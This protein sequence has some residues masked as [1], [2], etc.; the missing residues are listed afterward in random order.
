[1]SDP[2]QFTSDILSGHQ[3]IVISGPA[4]EY[5]YTDL[6]MFCGQLEKDITYAGDSF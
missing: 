6:K 4:Y 2:N 1:M 5:I 3:N